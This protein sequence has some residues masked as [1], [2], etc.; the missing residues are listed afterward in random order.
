M[1]VDA[2]TLD[3]TK[4][5]QAVVND[6]LDGYILWGY[7][8]AL[9]KDPQIVISLQCLLVACNIVRHI[10]EG[11]SIESCLGMSNTFQNYREGVEFL[12][13][14]MAAVKEGFDR[15]AL[16]LDSATSITVNSS[17]NVQMQPLGF[18]KHNLKRKLEEE[19]CFVNKEALVSHICDSAL[20]ICC[21]L[22]KPWCWDAALKHRLISH[23]QIP[24]IAAEVPIISATEMDVLLKADD[25]TNLECTGEDVHL[26]DGLLWTQQS[27]KLSTQTRSSTYVSRTNTVRHQLYR[28]KES[29]NFSLEEESILSAIL[30]AESL[31]EIESLVLKVKKEDQDCSMEADLEL[32]NSK[33]TI[34]RMQ[35]SS[36]PTTSFYRKREEISGRSAF[37]SIFKIGQFAAKETHSEVVNISVDVAA[38]LR[39]QAFHALSSR[40]QSTLA[41]RL[42]KLAFA[43]DS[44][45]RDSLVMLWLLKH[46]NPAWKQQGVV[47]IK[48][49]SDRKKLERS[50]CDVPRN[51]GLLKY[52]LL[53]LVEKELWDDLAEL[54][55]WGTSL[56]KD[57][58][59]MEEK[60]RE[61]KGFNEGAGNKGKATS[62]HIRHKRFAQTLKVAK[63]LGDLI[64]LCTSL[65]VCLPGQCSNCMVTTC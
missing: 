54:C 43:T 39:C 26:E 52:T 35:L 65:Q 41:K 59:G 14:L 58:S 63:T 17:D 7:R 28:A 33:T 25:G 49:L 10:I 62:G 20:Y 2:G 3:G 32:G 22:E 12:M 34:S 36:P 40:R 60:S 29:L 19:A 48:S 51:F 11:C 1:V 37:T 18:T 6:T 45:E 44:N 27:A 38:I 13:L 61:R 53:Y 9:E 15:E 46:A 23:T 31:R 30:R 5:I 42:Y 55:Q 64:Q 4:L 8:L 56:L 50:D 21:I 16:S 47:G 57:L 24:I